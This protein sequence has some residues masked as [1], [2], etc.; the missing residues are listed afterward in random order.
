MYVVMG[1]KINYDDPVKSPVI[2]EMIM[3]HRIGCISV[4][5]ARRLN[6]DP[7]LALYMFYGSKTC[8]DLHDKTTGLYL[9]S[10]LYIADEFEIE[11][12]K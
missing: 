5:I 7:V 10:N 3:S 1:E 12:K 6:I 9:Y 8:A 4:E 2:Q 11:Y